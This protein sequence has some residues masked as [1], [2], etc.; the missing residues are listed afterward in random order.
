MRSF[1]GE[2]G[3]R[4]W[5]LMKNLLV[6]WSVVGCLYDALFIIFFVLS[7]TEN[8]RRS[9]KLIGRVHLRIMYNNNLYELFMYNKNLIQTFWLDLVL[10]GH[11][12]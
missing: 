4:S 6:Y 7:S 11:G 10:Q 12:D 8:G 1:D 3:E 2:S 9:Q 5:A